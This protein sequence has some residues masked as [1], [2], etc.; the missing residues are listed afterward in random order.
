MHR[1]WNV[2][3]SWSNMRF[4]LKPKKHGYRHRR[5]PPVQSVESLVV[6]KM[7]YKVIL[8]VE[9]SAANGQ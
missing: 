3:S 2:N 4:A 6:L 1:V 8:P 7:L 9:K 5:E